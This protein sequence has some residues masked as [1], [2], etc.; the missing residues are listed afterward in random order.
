MKILLQESRWKISSVQ[1]LS[2]VQVFAIPWT[3]PRQA[4]LS[5]TNSKNLPKLMS[6]ESVMPSNHLILCH[7]LLLLPSILPASGSFLPSQF[8]ASGGQSIGVS[9]SAS[10]LSMNIQDRFPLGWTDWIFLQSKRLSRVFSNTTLQKHQFFG[11]QLSL[12][13][14]HPYMTTGKTTALTRQTF[15]GKVMSLL[16]N[17][18]SR[19]V[20][21]FLSRSKS[22]LISWLC[23]PSAVI[24]ET[25]KIV[26]HCLHC[27]PIYLPRSDGTGCHDFSFWKLSF[28]PTFSL[29]SFT[30]IKRLFCS[31]SLSAIRVVSYLRLLIFLPAILIPACASSSLAFLM[32][33]SA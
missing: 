18:L 8:F 5:I 21:A 1:S 17:R 27:F 25:K 28:K 26:C 9:A 22:L 19:L 13:N 10:V 30:F 15:A 11:A 14:S 23:S 3:I 33:Y 20:R 29:S 6:I 7:P 32:M 12:F 31:S 24:L 4:S 16:F 2:H